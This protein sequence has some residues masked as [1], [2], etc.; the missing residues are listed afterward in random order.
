MTMLLDRAAID[1]AI[2]KALAMN[3][4]DDPMSAE[5]FIEL[6][7][8][9]GRDRLIPRF[10]RFLWFWKNIDTGAQMFVD[11]ETLKWLGYTAGTLCDQQ[12]QFI[13]RL[14]EL[15][16]PHE[17]IDEEDAA[18]T[19]PKVATDIADVDSQHREELRWVVLTGLNVKLACLSARTETAALSVARFYVEVEEVFR[20][21]KA[22]CA[23]VRERQR[24]DDANQVQDLEMQLKQ[25]K[26]SL[27]EVERDRDEL[28]KRYV[29]PTADP[30]KEEVVAIIEMDADYVH[31]PGSDP[32][33]TKGIT[34]VFV[35]R[36]RYSL[37]KRL[38]DVR[39]WGKESNR[40]ADWLYTIDTP[41]S[42]QLFL[43]FQD[44]PADGVV[45]MSSFGC[46]LNAK[47]AA[48]VVELLKNAAGEQYNGR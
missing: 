38:A 42:V 16:V 6:V 14:D 45:K 4:D 11:A 20:A 35:R 9:V 5:D 3:A 47:G 13:G 37:K 36:Q 28:A 2:E 39:R 15:D 46:T 17:V 32:A 10:L 12:Q 41:N 8:I 27:D 29:P 23:R 43:A 33:Y 31:V 25:L 19:W 22:Y 30:R 26:L 1:D 18:V 34:H 7:D 40:N 24:D 21:Y 48:V 44:M